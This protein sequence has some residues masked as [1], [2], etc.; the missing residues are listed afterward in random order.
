MTIF[1]RAGLEPERMAYGIHG[2][3][4]IQKQYHKLLKSGL[5]SEL[6]CGKSGA[7]HSGKGMRSK[8]MSIS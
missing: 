7:I 1:L 8:G 3:D 4:G 5:L 6:R 2:T